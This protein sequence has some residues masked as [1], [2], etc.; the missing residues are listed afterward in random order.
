MEQEGALLPPEPGV[1]PPAAIA[2]VAPE[3]RIELLDILRGFALFGILAANMRGFAAPAAVYFDP[4]RLWT[5]PLNLGVQALVDTFISGKFI[6][7]FSLLFGIGFAMQF[8]RSRDRAG[9]FGGFYARRSF[10]LL[11]I[12]LAHAFLLWFGDILIGYAVCSFLL[13]AFRR[14]S[15]RKLFWWGMGFYW[16]PLLPMGGFYLAKQLGAD[17]PQSPLPTNAQL[18]E[19]IRIYSQGSFAEIFRERARE[20]AMLNKGFLFFFTRIIGIFLLGMWLWRTGILRDPTEHRAALQRARRLGLW[21]GLPGSIAA[22]AFQYTFRPDPFAPDLAMIGMMLIG[23]VAIPALSVFYCSTVILWYEDSVW[24]ERLRTFA[25]VGRTALTNYLAQSLIATT[26]FYG[27]GGGLFGKVGPPALLV[28]TVVIYAAQI[29]LSRA[30]TVR[31][32]Y[33]P[34]EWLWRKLSYGR[35]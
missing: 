2:P 5:D 23:S 1:A 4:F 13:L 24:R 11:A 25:P 19:T 10:V 8:D 33:G 7:I 9:S 30:W 12:G 16:L 26:I 20:W 22:I 28:L 14:A 21:I 35:L 3:E 18:Q 34:M 17:M 6:T 15:Q 27:Y 31:F 29:Q 32:R